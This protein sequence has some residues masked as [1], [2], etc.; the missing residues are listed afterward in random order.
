[1]RFVLGG[2]DGTLGPLAL[3]KLRLKL[4]LAA[5]ETY[6]HTPPQGEKPGWIALPWLGVGIYAL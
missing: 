2:G 3:S 5:I 1:L 4:D 6:N